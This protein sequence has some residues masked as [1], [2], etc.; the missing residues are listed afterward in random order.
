ML[1]NVKSNVELRKE[2]KSLYK[3]AMNLLEN[4][5]EED[6]IT[7]IALLNKAAI[8]HNSDAIY[9]LGMIYA[10]G[11]IVPQDIDM[12]R[13]YFE[14]G[15]E[16]GDED[17]TCGLAITYWD[18]TTGDED[19]KKA[20]EILNTLPNTSVCKC[21]LMAELLYFEGE[22]LKKL[23]NIDYSNDD[24]LKLFKCAAE[25]GDSQACYRLGTIYYEGDIAPKNEKLAI[26]YL[27]KG[28]DLGNVECQYMLDSIKEE[29][30]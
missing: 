17:C 9:E 18:S 2:G 6:S 13:A 27:N 8:F 20:Y 19:L 11:V 1:K 10:D 29:V 23:V 3:Q 15:H 4:N 16:L 7:A 21:K 25:L 24:I 26:E 14:A 12:C 5:N 22:S 30:K 28:I